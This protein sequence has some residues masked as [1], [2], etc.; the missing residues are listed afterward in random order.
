M[1]ISEI[2]FSHNNQIFESYV[3]PTTKIAHAIV[4]A[5]AILAWGALETTGKD[6]KKI[7]I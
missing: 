3:L 4:L 5:A 7:D 1:K 2:I 6:A